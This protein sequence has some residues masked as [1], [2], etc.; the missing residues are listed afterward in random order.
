VQPQ[1][2]TDY[3]RQIATQ[4]PGKTATQ[5]FL[6]FNQRLKTPTK[7][8]TTKRSIQRPKVLNQNDVDKLLQQRAGTQKRQK[9]Y[10][11]LVEHVDQAFGSDDIFRDELSLADLS[12]SL[13][14][15][16]DDDSLVH[17]SPII[18]EH[19]FAPTFSPSNLLAS[20]P[21]RNVVDQYV[22]RRKNA[23]STQT[24]LLFR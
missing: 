7:K 4:V 21:N 18:N 19:N 3:W 6:K 16:D 20:R 17:S 2:G 9:I 1:V 12:F 8:I 23:S 5:C 24:K 10:R 14:S 13:T 15:S 22:H 11:E